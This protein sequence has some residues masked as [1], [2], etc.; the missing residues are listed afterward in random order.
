MYQVALGA[1]EE[2]MPLFKKIL[3]YLLHLAK[4]DSNYDLRDRA[5][6]MEKLLVSITNSCPEED[7]SCS[8]SNKKLSHEVNYIFSGK[9]HSKSYQSDRYKVYLPGSLS[10]IVLHAAPGYKSF[11]MPCSLHDL[12]QTQGKYSDSASVLSDDDSDTFSGSS[13]EKS[14]YSSNNS[15]AV[16]SG[17]FDSMDNV[18]NATEASQ[19]IIL[20]AGDD[21]TKI[22]QGASS[23]STDLEELMSKTSL[24]SW[25]EEQ[26]SFSGPSS[27][28]AQGF[29]R[30]ASIRISLKEIAVSVKPKVHRLFEPTDGNGLRVDFSFSAETSKISPVLVC[31]EL[32]FENL[33]AETLTKLAIKDTDEN[34]VTASQTYQSQERSFSFVS[35]LSV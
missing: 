29:E 34:M 28:S 25:L 2:D 31:V 18:Q 16:S 21:T 11:P 35:S 6:F 30:Q 14:D 10:Q 8:S 7:I 3:M 19:L 20:D 27:F 12:N 23:L 33:S 15:N 5:H 22:G 4:Y 24:E 13:D 17:M 1:D 9:F 32:S 26:P